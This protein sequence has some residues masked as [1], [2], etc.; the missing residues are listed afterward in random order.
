MQ[1]AVRKASRLH[2]K[3]SA[4]RLCR[5]CRVLFVTSPVVQ[6]A[7]WR[8]LQSKFADSSK[9][10]TEGGGSHDFIDH[11]EVGREGDDTREAQ[12]DE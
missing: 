11:S 3:K 10:S 7:T 9:G 2:S 12:T 8:R 4:L 6:E 5:I 1:G